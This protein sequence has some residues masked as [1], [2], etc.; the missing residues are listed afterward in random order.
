MVVI[1]TLKRD[2]RY[3]SSQKALTRLLEGVDYEANAAELFSLHATRGVSALNPKRVLHGAA[4]V[5]IKAS[6]EEM[7]V[8]S[9]AVT[10]KMV[11]LKSLLTLDEMIEHLRKYLISSYSDRMKAEGYTTITDKKTV[12]DVTLR[13]FIDAKRQLDYVVTLADLIIED[14]DA[15]SWSMKR[16]SDTL[17]QNLKDR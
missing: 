14:T 7:A 15:A 11:S 5:V 12:V 8:R 6:V 10:I 4:A 17:G 2:R 3:R 9:R 16:I 1:R 13:A